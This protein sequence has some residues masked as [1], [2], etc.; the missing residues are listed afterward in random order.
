MRNVWGVAKV[1]ETYVGKK[2]FEPK[3]PIFEQIRNAG[4]EYGATTGRPR[5]CNWIDVELFQK[6]IRMN[7]VT[8]L[9]FNKMD[10]L[11]KIGIWKIRDS[12]EVVSF[13]NG[14]EC[15]T[16]LRNKRKELGVNPH[17]IF[18]SESKEGI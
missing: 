10:V 16:F 9:V 11:N 5:Q 2:E 12:K 13:E 7:G 8:H 15:R 1:Y 18:F 6:A 14:D 17:N 4:E 3:D